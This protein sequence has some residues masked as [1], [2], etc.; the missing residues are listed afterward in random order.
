M[1]TMVMMIMVMMTMLKKTLREG[2]RPTT[3]EPSRAGPVT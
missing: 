3:L 2:S 1:T